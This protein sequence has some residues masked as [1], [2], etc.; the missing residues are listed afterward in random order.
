MAA[1]GRWIQPKNFQGGNAGIV[2]LRMKQVSEYAG[3]F[4]Y[5]SFYL[6]R[7][8]L[9]AVADDAGSPRIGDLHYRP[10]IGFSDPVLRHLLLS[11]RPALATEPTETSALYADHV[12]R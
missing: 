8:A 12:A 4:H 11:V 5:L 7:E 6:T 2:D 9:D 3:P 1:E 10:G